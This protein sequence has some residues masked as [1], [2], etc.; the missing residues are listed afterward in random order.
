M[1]RPWE[2]LDVLGNIKLRAHHKHLVADALLTL[3][4]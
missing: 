3:W 4:Y 2:E 1:C